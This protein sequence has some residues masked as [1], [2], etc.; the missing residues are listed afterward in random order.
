MRYLHG[1]LSPEGSSSGG[2]VLS[3]ADY[4]LMQQ[5]DAWQ[6]EYVAERLR[7]STCLFVGMSLSDPNLLRYL[8]RSEAHA[9]MGHLVC[10]ARQQDAALYEEVNDP[11]AR[12]R[13]RTAA[14]RWHAVG[15]EPLRVEH[16]AQSAQLLFEVAACRRLGTAYDPLGQRLSEWHSAVSAAA[17]STAARVFDARQDD[18]QSILADI[19]TATR[20]VLVAHT[21]ELAPGERLGCSLWVY[22][23]DGDVLVNWASSDRV[24]RDPATLEPVPVSWTSPFASVRAFCTGS[25]TSFSTREQVA[26]RWNHVLGVPLYLEDEGPLGRLPVGV[27]TIASTLPEE[28][29]ALGK[30]I[31]VVR[32][33]IAPKIAHQ[34]ADL[35]RPDE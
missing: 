35:L 17:L 10:F 33:D 13:E 9:A 12:L 23:P 1:R 11:V 22:R 14:Q 20:E 5:P 6:E 29:S 3:E 26:T 31:Q 2:L 28:S 34:L 18:L 25:L 8:Y 4:H 15:V 27:A 21:V 24:W 19:V 30:G 32:A 7:A 16:C